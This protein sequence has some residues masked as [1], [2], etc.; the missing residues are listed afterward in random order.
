MMMMLIKLSVIEMV[1]P[2]GFDII[3]SFSLNF[4]IVTIHNYSVSFLYAFYNYICIEHS[5]IS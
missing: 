1:K 4:F 2:L 5:L 3:T